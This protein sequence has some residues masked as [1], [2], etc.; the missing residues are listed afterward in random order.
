MP[1]AI[2]ALAAFAVSAVGATGVA[3]TVVSAVVT[4]G[5]NLAISA[6]LTYVA[7]LF[8]KR[9]DQNL[10][11]P[12]AGQTEF[13]QSV[14]PRMFHYG[15]VKTSGPL[16][17]F[18]SNPSAGE[19]GKVVL[20]SSREIEAYEEHYLDDL[21]VFTSGTTV[22]NEFYTNND[23]KAF[24]SAHLGGANQPVDALLLAR[25]PNYWTS[26]HR[27]RGIAYVAT[28]FED[29]EP[30][31]QNKT[32]PHGVPTY[33][34]LI[35]AS[36]L[37]DPRLDSSTGGNGA[38]R[39]NQPSTWEGE[40]NCALVILDYLTYVDGYDI[41]IADFDLASFRAFAAVCD[42]NVA[43]AAGGSERR[44]RISTTVRLNEPRTQVLDRLLVACDAQLYPTREGKIAVRGGS[45]TAPTVIIDAEAGHVIDA[46]FTGGP[47]AM[48]R[49]NSIPFQ[50]LSSGHG[51]TEVD[52]DPW[53]DAAD[54]ATTGIEVSRPFDLTQ[55]PSH[56]QARRLQKI[57]MARDNPAWVGEI[58]TNFYGLDAIGERVITFKWLELE[59]D[60]PFWVEEISLLEDGTGVS[61]KLR[62][63]DSD[64]YLWSV[65]EE[66][67]LPVLPGQPVPVTPVELL[68]NGTF[69]SA[70]SPPTLGN[71]WTISGGVATRIDLG[72][73][74]LISWG[75][76]NL[77]SDKRYRFTYTIVAI[78]SGSIKPRV[79]GGSGNRSG[80][81]R[82]DE[83]TF[84]SLL[85]PTSGSNTFGFVASADFAGSLDNVSFYQV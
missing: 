47:D 13:Q 10:P 82:F 45:W 85:N 51:Y 6:G 46:K 3:A 81:S 35:R 42:Q 37:Y 38:H 5:A 16:A 41:R 64:S 52:G 30:E 1:P 84:T 44:Y 69:S 65:T 57:R 24:L 40:N 25:F 62:S 70:S 4:V 59:I 72:A 14:P 73:T 63:A 17:F 27:L 36:R 2:A 18:E 26:N 12:S 50:Y 76:L 11:K 68:T 19:V 28:V 48:A 32:F 23:E 79:S 39:H 55:V 66:G 78:S 77:N 20:I 33:K 67:S 61:M 7:S 9:N 71:G 56:T 34:G 53:V 31:Y 60:G 22:N 21:L 83:G 54:I 75:G 43:F 80:P 49:Y 15:R 29:A 8:L 74:S 58:K